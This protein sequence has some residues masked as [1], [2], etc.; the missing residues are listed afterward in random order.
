MKESGKRA[1]TAVDVAQRAKVS[2]GTVSNVLNGTREVSERKIQAVRRA[3]KELGYT[4]NHSARSLKMGSSGLL[5]VVV[6]NSVFYAEIIEGIEAEIA[7]VGWRMLVGSSLEDPQ[8]EQELISDFVSQRVE[9]IIVVPVL[10]HRKSEE[11]INVAYDIPF[12][13]VDRGID[14]PFVGADNALGSYLATA[15]L[16]TVHALSRIHFMHGSDT[17]VTSERR[18]GFQKAMTENGLHVDEYTIHNGFSTWEGGYRAMCDILSLSELPVAVVVTNNFM[19]MGAWKAC[20]DKGLKIP[21]DVSIIGFDDAPWMRLLSPGLTAVKQPLG[22]IATIAV[23][24]IM[25][26]KA[27]GQVDERTILSDELIIRGSCGCSEHL[28]GLRHLP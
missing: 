7:K 8:R 28:A 15:H 10:N 14:T 2:L 9:G 4:P 13:Y 21:G 6:A 23:E 1:P 25:K 12:V 27:G 26:L 19:C 16:L 24:V 11:T 18:K 17:V 22:W 20:M 3:I 5:G